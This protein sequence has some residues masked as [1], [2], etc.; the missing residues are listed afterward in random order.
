M[1]LSRMG[2][3]TGQ[4]NPERAGSV[5]QRYTD[6]LHGRTSKILATWQIDSYPRQ[7]DA[8]LFCSCPPCGEILFQQGN[9]EE[10][11][12][13]HGARAHHNTPAT[14]RRA[15]QSPAQSEQ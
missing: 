5:E 13:A 4:P 10:E 1:I 15:K 3:R 12:Q 11:H 7:A 14:R 2:W 8:Y 6:T 9:S